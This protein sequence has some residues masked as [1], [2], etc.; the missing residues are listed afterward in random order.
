M[1][2]LIVYIM[3]MDVCGVGIPCLKEQMIYFIAFM[4]CFII[5][6][7]I[8]SILFACIFYSTLVDLFD[9]TQCF[10]DSMAIGGTH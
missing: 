1:C 2:V 5:L 10:D 9:L 7:N 3:Y 6:D 8:T 4:K